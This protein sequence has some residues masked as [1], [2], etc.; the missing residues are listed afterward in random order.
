MFLLVSECSFV[1]LSYFFVCYY[2]SQSTS[3]SFVIRRSLFI[4]RR[5]N[6]NFYGCKTSL[7]SFTSWVPSLL[8]LSLDFEVLK[9]FW[10]V[11]WPENKDLF[12]NVESFFFS[13]LPSGFP[14]SG[15]SNVRS[16][17]CANYKLLNK[18][19]IFFLS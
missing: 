1:Y 14:K 18:F 7:V 16:F 5:S 15:I 12:N 17:N 9:D 2:L 8:N 13:W 11:L 10:L 6:K 3:P 4:F 19:Y